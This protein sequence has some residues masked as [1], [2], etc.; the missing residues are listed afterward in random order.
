MKQ[1]ADATNENGVVITSSPGSIPAAR[2]Q[3]WRPA[4]PLETAAP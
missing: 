4:V 2:T 3:R 1:L